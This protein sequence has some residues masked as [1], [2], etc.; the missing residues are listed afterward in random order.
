MPRPG[1]LGNRLFD[2]L[3]RRGLTLAFAES[4]TGGRLSAGL[5][6]RP[7][8]S[9]FFLGATVVYSEEAKKRLLG[10][11][12]ETLR[13]F[14]AVSPQ[15]ALEM[16]RGLERVLP[17]GALAAVTGIAGPGGGSPEKPV[18]TVYGAFILEGKVFHRAWVFK[19]SRRRILRAC[20]G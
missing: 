5:V 14:G 11:R 9:A 15:T 8:A 2:R 1:R 12:E 18:G 3:L 4:L 7:G 19:G 17:A 6:E 16:V 13:N 10:V 20:A